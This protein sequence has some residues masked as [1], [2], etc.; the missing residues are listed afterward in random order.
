[1]K[2]LAESTLAEMKAGLRCIVDEWLGNDIPDE[3]DEDYDRWQMMLVDIDD[4]RS[5]SDVIAFLE[6]RG[7]DDEG[8]NEFLAMFELDRV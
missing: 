2:E 5:L 6:S 8:V 3:G 1:M 7:R 4:V